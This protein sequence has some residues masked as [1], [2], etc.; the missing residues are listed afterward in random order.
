MPEPIDAATFEAQVLAH[1]DALYGFVR[2]RLVD[3][4]A[5]EDVLQEALL[6]AWERRAQVRAPN[7]LR[8]WL[9]Q[10]VIN[11]LYE[12]LRRRR[13]LVALTALEEAV[14]RHVAAEDPTPLEVVLERVTNEQLFL[15]L[16][17]VPEDFA[18]AVELADL[19]GQSYR[20]IADILGVPIGTVMSRIYRGR[21]LLA[22]VILRNREAWGLDEAAARRRT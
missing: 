13:R 3:K 22:D 15:A 19:E 12:H 14:E 18:L 6:R 5:A 10:V 16:R 8:P 9:Y 2:R 4:S 20:E 7:L 11:S 21:R 1:L 17:M